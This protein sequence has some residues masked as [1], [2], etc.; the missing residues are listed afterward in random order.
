MAMRRDRVL[1]RARAF[2]IVAALLALAAPGRVEAS[3]LIRTS[4]QPTPFQVLI[5]PDTAIMGTPFTITVIGLAP[6]GPVTLE[7]CSTDK[8]GKEWRSSAVFSASGTGTVDVSSQAP[9]SG[10]Y[11]GADIFGLLWSMKAPVPP[12]A[13][14]S[15][16]AQDEVDGW[17]VD[18]TATD[19]AGRSA[20]A[21]LRRV[22]QM[23]GQALVRVALEKDGM[24]GFLYHPAGGGT[25]PGVLIL[26][27]SNG[28]LYEWLAQALASNGFAALT[29]AYFGYPRLPAELVEI[30][31]ENFHRAAVWMKEQP[32]VRPGRLGLAGGSKGG[33]L[34]LLLAS[35]YDDFRAVV[36]WTPAA[37]VWE[38]LSQAYFSPDYVPRSSW[39]AG[40]KALPFVG[41]SAR[42]E[43]KE[44]EQKGQLDSFVALH[45]RALAL[46]AP[47]ALERAAIPVERIKAPLLL[48]SGT[49]DQTWPADAFCRE[50]VARLHKAGFP[51]ELKHVSHADAGH[52]SFLPYLV[53]AR[54]API[55]GG[56]DRANAAAGFD[57]WKETVEFLRKHLGR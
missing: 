22:Y 17:T 33:E 30:P 24:S 31:I 10:S 45:Q 18:F 42:S 21:R 29:L 26:G 57:S 37:H 46:T 15:S 1:L 40:G 53:T 5:Q 43:D 25:F 55:N 20:S 11:T 49:L 6:G 41:F 16:Y 8:R 28:G 48:I 4:A 35:R 27:G 44:K 9:V 39:A 47:E 23:P 54:T 14:P 36:A 52:G 34:A 32:A 13:R 7:A 2:L 38:G 56:S 12:N 3:G 50:I 51:F 19:A